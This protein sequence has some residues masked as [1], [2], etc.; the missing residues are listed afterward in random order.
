MALGEEENG[1]VVLGRRRM[2]ESGIGERRRVV[3]GREE[4]KCGNGAAGGWR[5]VVL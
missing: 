4:I 2:G 3:V 1:G 5:K